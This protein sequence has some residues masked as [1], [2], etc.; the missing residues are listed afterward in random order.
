MSA[1]E[2]MDTHLLEP[3]VNK[4]GDNSAQ[5]HPVNDGVDELSE[6]EF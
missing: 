3:G 6:G 5:E 1:A 4:G 2:C